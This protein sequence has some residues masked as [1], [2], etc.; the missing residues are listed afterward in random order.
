MP[1]ELYSDESAKERRE[2]RGKEE[3]LEFSLK[4]YHVSNIEWLEGN[5]FKDGADGHYS[6]RGQEILNKDNMLYKGFGRDCTITWKTIPDKAFN[7]DIAVFL[8]ADNTVGAVITD[9]TI[10]LRKFYPRRKLLE[11]GKRHGGKVKES[12]K[13]SLTEVGKEVQKQTG[14][15]MKHDLYLTVKHANS[16]EVVVHKADIPASE[17]VGKLDRVH[18]WLA[19]NGVLLPE[20]SGRYTDETDFGGVFENGRWFKPEE[21]APER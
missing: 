11:A 10:D 19:E 18:F 5:K 7:Y 16:F 21:N 14:A 17:A 4:T 8:Y 3:K 20:K 15:H 12:L 2:A 13:G 6:G 1:L 9:L